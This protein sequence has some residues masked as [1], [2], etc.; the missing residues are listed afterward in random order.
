MS[1]RS[2]SFGSSESDQPEP[3][4]KKVVRNDTRPE[5]QPIEH[6]TPQAE[7]IMSNMQDFWQAKQSNNSQRFLGV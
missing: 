7:N 2:H 5:F 1:S 6:K 3:T 4:P